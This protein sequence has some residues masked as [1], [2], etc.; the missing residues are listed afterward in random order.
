ML[1]SASTSAGAGL[2]SSSSVRRSMKFERPIRLPRMGAGIVQSGDSRSAW[3][4]VQSRQLRRSAARNA[5]LGP[6]LVWLSSRAASSSAQAS[7]RAGLP[8]LGAGG[9]YGAGEYIQDLLLA[10]D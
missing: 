1:T 4:M 2:P 6:D 9:R 10:R 7:V 8:R 5:S 3:K